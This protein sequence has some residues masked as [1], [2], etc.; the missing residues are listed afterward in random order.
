[1]WVCDQEENPSSETF[2]EGLVKPDFSH[3]RRWVQSVKESAWSQAPIMDLEPLGN[4]SW[5]EATGMEGPG[6]YPRG[7]SPAGFDTGHAA[8]GHGGGPARP[9]VIL[10]TSPHGNTLF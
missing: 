7:A 1:M 6:I 3:W 4:V 10:A 9:G 2:P 5:D 8:A